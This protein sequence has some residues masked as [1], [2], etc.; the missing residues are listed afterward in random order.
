MQAPLIEIFS[1]IQGEGP[2]VG[3]QMLF[4]RFLKCDLACAFCDT[5]STFQKLENFRVE[6]PP[7]SANFKSYP[8]PISS[9]QLAEIISTF[10]DEIISLTGGE[11]L[12]YADF[13]NDFLPRIKSKHKILL[14]TAGTRPND[15]SK[16]I[17]QIDIVSMDIKLPSSAETGSFWPEHEA[18]LQIARQK[19]VYV[20]SVVTENTLETDIQRAVNLVHTIAP[21][22]E[23]IL[24]PNSPGGRI[25]NIISK[26]KLLQLA[27]VAK[28]LSK[29]IRVIPQVHKL[30][31]WL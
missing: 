12:L 29:K 3:T 22:A 7:F 1:S 30:Q 11:P 16:V 5:P 28:S 21:E 25:K 23:F 10:D 8:N 17:E 27:D 19:K 26:E 31:G 24:Q 18:F 20:K 4:V 2:Y 13:L 9:Q 14:E 15:L 6:A